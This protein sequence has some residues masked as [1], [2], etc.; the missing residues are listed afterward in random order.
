MAPLHVLDERQD[1][2]G[3]ETVVLVHGTLD[4]SSTFGRTAKHLRAA[5]F[6]VVRYDRRGYGRSVEAGPGGIDEHVADLRSVLDGGAAIVAGHSFGGVVALVT[7]AQEPSL[8]RAVLAYEAPMPWTGWWPTNSAGSVAVSTGAVNDRDPGDVAE[9]FM[10]RMVGDD[11]WQRLPPATRTA[12]RAEGVAM[13]AELASLRGRADAPY[14][15]EAIRC[16]VVA[17]CGS[18]SAAHHRRA[19]AELAG[20]IAGARLAVVDGAQHGVHLTHPAELARLV[21]ELAAEV[22]ARS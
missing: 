10:R 15:P 9:A 18:E 17:A 6:R 22:H 16:P 14:L 1:E 5:G 11:R 4:R 12:R 2:P 20:E 21:V 7:A 3:A 13:I 19:A 8:V